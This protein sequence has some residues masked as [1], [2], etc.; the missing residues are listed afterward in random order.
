MINIV[1]SKE[2]KL[3]ILLAFVALFIASK[4]VKLPVKSEIA[5]EVLQNKNAISGL[6]SK[7]NISN[8]KR[9]NV[10]TINFQESRELIHPQLGS[11][12]FKTNFF[13]NATTYATVH[14]KGKYTFYIASDDGFRFSI[15]NHIV[16]EYPGNRAF[17]TNT[18]SF[19]LDKQTYLF[20]LSYYQGGGPMGLRAQYKLH[21][22]RMLIGHDSKF[23]TFKAKQ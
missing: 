16:C 23:I 22:K 21:S 3:L 13:I 19:D 4:V 1:K 20:N 6:D 8:T 7:K 17:K 2:G 15:D 11:L 12:G 18:C 14:K 5:I 10:P 9:F